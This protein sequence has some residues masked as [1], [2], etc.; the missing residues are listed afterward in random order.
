MLRPSH[1][2]AY[3]PVKIRPAPLSNDR[4]AFAAAGVVYGAHGAVAPCLICCY[5]FAPMQFFMFRSEQDHHWFGFTSDVTGDN[6]PVELAPWHQPP[7][8]AIPASGELAA[9]TGSEPFLTL[10]EETGYCTV[11][12]GDP[13][14]VWGLFGRHRRSP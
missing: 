5:N 8:E 7:C 3:R 10:I 11:R 4:L 13:N 6:L 2:A 12:I 9:I 1:R 14:V